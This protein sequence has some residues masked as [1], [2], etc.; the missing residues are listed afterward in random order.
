MFDL[1]QAIEDWKQRMAEAG[2]HNSNL[3][4]ELESHLRDDIEAQVGSG[5]TSQQAFEAA[6][7]R[8]GQP[9]AL[10][11]EFKKTAGWYANLQISLRTLGKLLIGL[12]SGSTLQ[13]AKDFNPAA[14]HVLELARKEPKR[15]HHHFVGTEHVLLG[16]LQSESA[17]PFR[18]LHGLGLNVETVRLEIEK[19]IG[20]G[21]A[22]EPP[23]KIPFTPRARRALEL[24]A[25][26]AKT[27]KHT[28]IGPEHILLGLLMEG[29]G[30]AG[31]VLKNLGVKVSAAREEILKEFGSRP[32]GNP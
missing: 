4:D 3:I 9:G 19:C 31:M 12:R 29:H 7:Q 25:R 21:S 14:E 1:N 16:L 8:L 20:L 6:V 15:F 22:Q 5:L 18:I 17:S 2:L 26:E 32:S 11:A 13:L 28:R 27:M 30:V 10:R 24:A 23:A